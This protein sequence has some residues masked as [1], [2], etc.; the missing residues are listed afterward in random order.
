MSTKLR[1]IIH[2]DMDAFYASIEQRDHP[3]LRGRPI[4]VGG[5]PDGRGVVA[6]ASYEARAFGIHSAMPCGRAAR[7]CPDAVFVSPN[8]SKYRAASQEIRAIF[9]SVTH[10]VEPLSLDEAYLDVTEN[11]L[12]E[13]LAGKIA[14]HIMKRIS[15]ELNLTA[16]AGVGPNKFIAKVA[17]DL[18]KPNGCT[19]IPPGKV[20]AFV[21][22]LPIEKMWSVGPSTAQKLHQMNVRNGADL[23]EQSLVTLQA[24]F[25][26][27]GRFLYG[28]A[29]GEDFRPVQP[30]RVP[31]SRAAETT[32][33]ADMIDLDDLLS[34]LEDL[35]GRVEDSLQK[36][37]RSG[38]T[39]TIKIRYSDFTT[40]TRSRTVSLPLRAQHKIF[41]TA[42]SL[43]QAQSEVGKRPV[44]LIGVSVGNLVDKDHALQLNFGFRA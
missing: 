42:M 3:E 14:L 33:A 36:I 37:D 9:R 26:K 25:G 16:S 6:T 7:L 28:L 32:F 39:V 4:I 44:R 35:C 10:L 34:T 38:R 19:I 27:Q 1:K 23:R 40:H 17:S 31:K 22:Q 13:P 8:F 43:L 29:R 30:N 18:K 24:R 2:I 5:K 11:H 15:E 21:A 12:S 20:A 41:E